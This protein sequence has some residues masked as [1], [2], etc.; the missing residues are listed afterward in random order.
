MVWSFVGSC[1]VMVSG[2]WLGSKRTGCRVPLPLKARKPNPKAFPFFLS[3][4][5]SPFAELSKNT[6]EQTKDEKKRAV[7][8]KQREIDEQ[9]QKMEEMAIEFGNMLK[10]VVFLFLSLS[11]SFLKRQRT[12]AVFHAAQSTLDKMNHRMEENARNL[13]FGADSIDRAQLEREFNQVIP[14]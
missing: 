9:K 8:I 5:S 14:K 13:D 11:L 4:S 1:F 10:V 12:D 3:E 6:L 7:E 2:R